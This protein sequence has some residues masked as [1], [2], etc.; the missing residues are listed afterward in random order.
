VCAVSEKDVERAM[1][2]WLESR[3]RVVSLAP[4]NLEDVGRSIQEVADALGVPERG[5]NWWRNC[6][7]G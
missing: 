2:E 3:P 4:N 5:G 6:G 1:C 7:S